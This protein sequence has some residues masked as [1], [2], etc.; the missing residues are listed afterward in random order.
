MGLDMY[1]N[2]E[3]FLWTNFQE[4]EKNITED[5]FE[6]KRKTFELGYWRKHPDLHGYI[7]ENFADG[8]DECQRIE[9]YAEDLEDILASVMDNNLPKTEGFFFGV[10]ESADEQ[11]TIRILEGAIK[12]LKTEEAGI[13]RS[14]YYRAS[15]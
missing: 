4:P 15:W 12:W 5:G 7:V 11:D 6:L 8:V 14:V 3:K 1:L 10:S 13:N 9:L 2:G